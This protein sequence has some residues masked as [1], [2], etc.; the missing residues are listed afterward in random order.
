MLAESAIF[1]PRSTTAV[2]CTP[3]SIAAGGFNSAETRAK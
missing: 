1:A 2:L 3:A